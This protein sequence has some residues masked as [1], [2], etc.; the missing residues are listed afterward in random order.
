VPIDPTTG[1][2]SGSSPEVLK[3]QN[4]FLPAQATTR[5]DYRASLASDPLTTK[6]DTS[7]PG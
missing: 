2:P 7:V 6:R 3:F 5:N 4:D 1:N